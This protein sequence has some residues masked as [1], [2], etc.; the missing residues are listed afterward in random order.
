MPPRSFPS[1]PAKIAISIRGFATAVRWKMNRGKKNNSPPQRQQPTES[2]I[3]T[4]ERLANLTKGN[5]SVRIDR[6][7]V[8]EALEMARVK[9]RDC[10]QAERLEPVTI[11][12]SVK[13]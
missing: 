11:I 6:R 13:A 3:S 12:D 4:S 2:A 7:A 10:R 9:S 1:I 8:F 5:R